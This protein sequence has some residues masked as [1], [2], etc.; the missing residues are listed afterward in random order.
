MRVR[1]RAS[2]PAKSIMEPRPRPLAVAV[3]ALLCILSLCVP[4]SP[5][6][7]CKKQEVAAA[8]VVLRHCPF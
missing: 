7:L 3:N 2:S 8:L 1:R 4:A 5:L 6:P